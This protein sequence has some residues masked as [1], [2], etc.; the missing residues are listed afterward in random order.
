MLVG[1]AFVL[2]QHAAEQ[3]RSS[4]FLRLGLIARLLHNRRW[5]AGLAVLI[6]GDLLW[7]WTLGHLDLSVSEPLLTTNLIFAL[8]LA[9]P[10]S[11]QA[12]RRT[13]VIGALLLTAGVAALSLT[14]SV[15]APGLSFGSFSHWPAAGFIAL[16]AVALVRL[17]RKRSGTARATLTG[18]A[19]GL[20]LGIADAFTRVSV[21][22]IDGD[23]PFGVLT[24]WPAYAT[25]LASIIGLWL[26]QNAFNAAHLHASLPAVTAA[27][28]AA[29]IVLGV[30][31]FGD[32]VHVSP[33]LLA[34]Q[35]AGIAAI[36][37]GVILVAR[38]PVFRDL[39]VAQ[40]PHAALERL[41]HL[42]V[43]HNPRHDEGG[44]LALDPDGPDPDG[45]SDGAEVGEP[46]AEA[47]EGTELDPG[48]GHRE[49][50]DL[51]VSRPD[52]VGQPSGV[53][54]SN[55]AAAIAKGAAVTGSAALKR[56]DGRR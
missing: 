48:D 1:F 40:L 43:A 27:E 7:A 37:S 28:P 56:L 50:G 16:I 13:E 52:G 36:V 49:P 19:A 35:I 23:H 22:E 25:V 39:H 47:G 29:G 45:R 11:G 53:S 31:V 9:V 55:A 32:V 30:V 41:Q 2:Q 33:L 54:Q 26:M 10:L 18:T 15:R 12:L 8:V 21:L 51:L 42:P 34:L 46:C 6:V 44:E 4:Q 38:A 17:G 20:F 24:H 5:L 14:R 3:V